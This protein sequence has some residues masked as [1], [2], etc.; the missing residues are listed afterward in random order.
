MAVAPLSTTRERSWTRRIPLLPDGLLP[1][2]FIAPAM[3]AL[4]LI[5]AYPMGYSFWLSLHKY[6]L[7]SPPTY[8]GLRN[9]HRIWDDEQ[10]HNSLRVTFLFAIP[11]LL[12]NLMLGFALAL[13]IHHKAKAKAVWRVLFSLPILLTPVVI[14][15]NWRVLLNYDFGSI[16]YYLTVL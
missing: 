1:V 8:V 7:L 2:I 10:V 11:V 13:L 14:G 9:Y 4:L 6:D 15:L 12:I 16:N 3:I 5:M